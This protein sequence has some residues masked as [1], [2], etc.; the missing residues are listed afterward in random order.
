MGCMDG[1]SFSPVLN[2][3][4]SA[5]S[6]RLPAIAPALV[7][8]A[9]STYLALF[10]LGIIT[11]VWEPFFGNGSRLILKESTVARLLPVP[12]A[13]LGALVYLAEAAAECTGGRQRFRTSPAAVFV[14][15]ALA[16]GLALAAVVLIGCQVLWFR[17]YCTLCLTSAV[18]SLL[19]AGLV[20]PEVRAAW[21]HH[22]RFDRESAARRGP[23]LPALHEQGR[24]T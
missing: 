7:G 1:I 11:E 24:K 12:D 3:S 14:T 5:W 9:I 23:G 21:N 20:L 8:C 13:A 10:Q 22:Q 19:I 18:C 15:G 6:Q 17:A 16:G 2:Q 4:P